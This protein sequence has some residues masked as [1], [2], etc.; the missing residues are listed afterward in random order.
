MHKRP[1]SVISET[2]ISST[3]VCYWDESQAVKTVEF[4]I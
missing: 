1:T 2:G 3:G 4:W